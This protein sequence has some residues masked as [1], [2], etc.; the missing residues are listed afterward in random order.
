[1]SQLNIFIDGSWL[2]KV[3]GPGHVLAAK[4]ENPD[5]GVRLDFGRLDQTL[6]AHVRAHDPAC[7]ELG[8]R[9]L[10]TSVFSLPND[11]EA[12]PDNN[13]DILPDH[14]EQTRRSIF[15]RNRFV[16]S[17]LDA[18]YSAD[19]V[20]RPNL[21]PWILR[22][23]IQGTYQEKQVDTTVV[24]LLVRYAITQPNDCHCIITGDADLLP[25]VRVA[26]PE[27]TENVFVATTH[28]DELR[29]EHRHT[30]FSF[31]NF[32]FRVAPFYFQDHL[33]EIIAGDFVYTC[34]HCHHVFVRQRPIPGGA[35]PCCAPCNLQRT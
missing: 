33:A 3:C 31:A 27:Y 18:D 2:F 25:A 35:R 20:L 30:A 9:F 11:L 19:A 28:P 26:Y 8:V 24:A 16:Q 14:V 34:A 1:M 7:D 22:R 6:L 32:E 23:L 29:A 12:W 15:A 4:A 21:R 10:A 5:Y 17:A 13:H